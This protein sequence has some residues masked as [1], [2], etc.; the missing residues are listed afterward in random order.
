MLRTTVAMTMFEGSPAGNVM[1]SAVRSVIN[2]RLIPLWTAKTTAAYIKKIINS[3]RMELD[4]Y[5]EPADPT[6]ANSEH[7]RGAG[8]GWDEMK[9]AVEAVY[10]GVPVLP[11]VM[12]ALTD[13]Q[14][15][16]PLMNGVFRFD[17]YTLDSQ[18]LSRAHGHDKRISL[19][20][21]EQEL[22]FYKT[23]MKLL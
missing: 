3:N 10:P 17:P 5:N 13:S 7:V 20:N 9:T 16:A 14:H 12:A 4:Y 23:L 8:P 11:F 22:C 21:F 6:P 2:M 19:E 15:Y 18:E 1:P